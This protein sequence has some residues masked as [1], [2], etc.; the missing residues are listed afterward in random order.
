MLPTIFQ[1]IAVLSLSALAVAQTSNPVVNGQDVSWMGLTNSALKL[2][3][4]WGVPFAQPPT[5]PLRFKPPLP[6]SPS[7]E[8]QVNA[9]TYGASCEQGVDRGLPAESE[10]CLTLNIWKPSNV[11]GKIP[12]MVWLYGGGFYFGT[13]RDYS[14]DGL[15]NVSIATVSGYL[16]Q[17]A[18]DSGMLTSA[19]ALQRRL[20]QAYHPNVDQSSR[21]S[22]SYTS[23]Q[24]TEQEFLDAAAKASALNLGLK[25]QRLALEWVQKNIGY[26]G[27][28]PNKARVVLPSFLTSILMILLQV[29]LF[30]QSAGAIS[31]SYQALYNGG[32]IGNVFRGMI[33]ESGS[34]SSFVLHLRFPTSVAQHV[35]NRVNVPP[36]NDTVLEAAYS[37]VVQATGCTGS[38][39]TFECV[40]SAP[41]EAPT[42]LTGPDQG[43]VV[44]GPTLAPGDV[45]LPELPSESVHAGRLAK[46]PFIATAQ[47]DEGTVFLNP[48]QPETE[49][50]LIDWFTAQ[51]P[52]LYFGYNNPTAVQELLKFYP[53]D[54]AAGSPYG[55]GNETFGSAA[56]YKR[57]ASAVG[58]LIFQVGHTKSATSYH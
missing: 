2:D 50:D 48:D 34:P 49:Q 35:L 24:T 30:G 11:T 42:N 29:I 51:I 14:G 16:C 31:T 55:T 58:D 38:S 53:T 57:L 27:G 43:P 39:D 41:I 9:T 54:P 28:D 37:F 52:G 18:R 46:V 47:L 4:F 1:S 25:D 56:Q 33:L 17:I 26:F 22:R 32:N 12:V 40:R 36:A 3:Y 20:V 15:V 44:I 10:D 8:T 45:F 21:E 23:L 13:A 19:L 7:N 5:G 6:W